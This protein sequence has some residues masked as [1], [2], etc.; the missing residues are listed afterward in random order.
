MP[1]SKQFFL[2][3]GVIFSLAICVLVSCGS[4]EAPSG[5]PSTSN[6]TPVA[7]TSPSTQANSESATISQEALF[8]VQVAEALIGE[9]I[10]GESESCLFAAAQT[11]QD[12]ADAVS[13]VIT[14]QSQLSGKQFSNLVTTVRDCVGLERMNR[15]IAIGLSLGEDNE[16]LFQCLMEQTTESTD[17]AAFVGLAAVTVRYPIPQDFADATIDILTACVSDELLAAQLSLQYLQTRNFSVEVDRE[18]V[19]AELASTG[20]A[21]DFWEA[22]FLTQDAERLATVAVLVESCGKALYEGLLEVVPENFEPWEGQRELAAVAPPA[23][24]NAYTDAPPMTI[25]TT[26]TYQA[27]ITTADGEMTFDLLV[28]TAPITANN[29]VN[30]AEDGFYD[31]VIFHRV[32]EDFMAQSGDPSG[33]GT[34]GPGYQFNDEVEDGPAMESRGLL[35]M[36]NAGPNTNGSQFFIT[37]APTPYLTGK[38]TVFGQLTQ[39]EEVLAAIDLRDPANPVSHGEVILNIHIVGP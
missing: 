22:A 11:N 35:A 5:E 28:E 2:S 36:A 13:A 27:I 16:D 33:Q 26:G 32:L 24:I 15:A 25:D 34:G 21:G 31:G 29:F 19:T 8:S 4:E 14:N 6:E 7:T 39:G 30:L 3:L 23:R 38:H 9:S 37:F 20:I 12:F 10:G 18:C 17:N 1:L